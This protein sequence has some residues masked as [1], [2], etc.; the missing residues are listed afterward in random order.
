MLLAFS[1]PLSATSSDEG[2]EALPGNRV[3]LTKFGALKQ[4]PVPKP[5][6][7]GHGVQRSKADGGA[8][9]PMKYCPFIS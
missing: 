4:T 2:S 6:R 9:V 5:D 7:S 8:T 1:A 3:Y